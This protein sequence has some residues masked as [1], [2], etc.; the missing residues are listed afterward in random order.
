LRKSTES[1][2][3]VSSGKV[4]MLFWS[5]LTWAR[6]WRVH[7]N[8]I[9]Y[10]CRWSPLNRELFHSQITHTLVN[11]H[12]VFDGSGVNDQVRGKRLSFENYR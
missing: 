11:G 10:K 1:V 2:K 4:I 3:G 9:R 8:N 6:S 5:C 12:I 7:P